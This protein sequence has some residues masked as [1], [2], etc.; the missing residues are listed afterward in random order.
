MSSSARRATRALILAVLA[1]LLPTACAGSQLRVHGR[2]G[3]QSPTTVVDAC[4]EL[5]QFQLWIFS[6]RQLAA[7][8]DLQDQTRVV[9]GL[10]AAGANLTTAE[11]S[12]EADVQA[13]LDD[14]VS[15][16]SGSRPRKPAADD[17][18]TPTAS[19]RAITAYGD[20]HCA[21]RTKRSTSSTTIPR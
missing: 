1:L 14:Q 15:V 16:L 18:A 21:G 9:K 13:I 11:P 4:A 8:A 17:P 5:E 3:A 2:E 6:A 20:E 12:L 19:Y 7:D 10:S